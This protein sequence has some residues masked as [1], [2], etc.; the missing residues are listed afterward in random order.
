VRPSPSPRSRA[1]AHHP[2]ARLSGSLIGT[3]SLS[4]AAIGDAIA[5]CVLAVVLASLGA[6]RG[7][8]DRHRRRLALSAVMISLGPSLFA[9]LGRLAEREHARADR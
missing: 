5:W 8:G 7:R 3:L 6:G 9:P 2:G 1:R 4:A